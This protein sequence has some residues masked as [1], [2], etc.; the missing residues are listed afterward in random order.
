MNE[1]ELKMLAEIESGTDEATLFDLV[2]KSELASEEKA[3]LMAI[4]SYYDYKRDFE[5]RDNHSIDDGIALW[6]LIRYITRIE[7]PMRI[8][9]FTGMLYPNNDEYF[10]SVLT[11]EAW[12]IIQRQA[13]LMIANGVYENEEH[14]NWLGRV[15]GGEFVYGYSI[16]N[17]NA[18]GGVEEVNEENEN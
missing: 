16:T 3:A 17:P 10:A 2:A 14:K 11:P 5:E 6:R 15:A 9:D 1:T 13:A 4:Q 18:H 7:M 8:I 12:Q